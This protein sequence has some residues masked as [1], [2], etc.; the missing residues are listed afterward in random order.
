[1]TEM[2]FGFNIITRTEEIMASCIMLVKEV[3]VRY[4]DTVTVPSAKKEIFKMDTRENGY[5]FKY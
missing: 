5:I 2:T 1:M 3:S 4:T